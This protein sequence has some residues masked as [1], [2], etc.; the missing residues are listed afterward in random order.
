MAKFLYFQDG[1]LKGKNAI[2]RTGNYFEDW[3]LKFDE[4][5]AIAKE[6]KVEAIL[7]GG[8]LLDA[9][10]PSYRVLDEIADRVEKAKIPFYCLFGNHAERYHSIQHSKY[11][12][13]AHLIKR[14]KYFH[15]MDFFDNHKEEME[16][17]GYIIKPMEYSHN[18]EQDIKDQGIYFQDTK[19]WKIAI[20]HAFITPKPFLPQVMHVCCN[21]IKTNADIVLVAHYHSEWEKQVDS[22][23]YKDI[24]CFGRNSITEAKITP[25]C[26]I[27]DTKL[28]TINEI[29]LKASKKA[30][31]V[32][33]LEKIEEIKAFDSNIEH[34]IKSLESTEFQSMN[35]KGIIEDIAKQKNIDR[36]VVDLVLKKMGGIQDES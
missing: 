23:L 20:V 27:I 12:G 11:T 29:N 10:E 32:F 1:H 34:F 28:K 9:P 31:E 17:E 18:V 3:L 19:S 21:D 14:S 6:H 2:N 22:T 24:G 26:L 33:D 7:D 13:L 15:Y 8:D 4:L 16:T 36:E 25:S 35:I 5:L 30:E